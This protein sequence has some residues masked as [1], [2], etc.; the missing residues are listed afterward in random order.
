MRGWKGR[1]SSGEGGAALASGLRRAGASSLRRWRQ[2][3]VKALRAR[4]W[5]RPITCAFMGNHVLSI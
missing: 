1:G 5:A 2:I 3:V 4:G